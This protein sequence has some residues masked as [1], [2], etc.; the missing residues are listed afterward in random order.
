MSAHKFEFSGLSIAA[1][2]DLE[3]M[4]LSQIAALKQLLSQKKSEYPKPEAF[5]SDLKEAGREI[6]FSGDST[7]V[8]EEQGKKLLSEIAELKQLLSKKKS[9]H[10]KLEKYLSALKEASRD[11]VEESVLAELFSKV[12]HIDKR[13]LICNIVP[14]IGG[15]IFGYINHSAASRLK[16]ILEPLV[17]GELKVTCSHSIHSQ[18]TLEIT[19]PFSKLESLKRGLTLSAE[20]DLSA[21]EISYIA[22][23]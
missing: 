8:A 15:E 10:R 2:V 12:F 4:L 11:K 17:D 20:V 7:V 13:K 9:Q 18:E 1:A 6:E 14:E 22:M 23:C 16:E 21:H 3:K 5:P 19:F